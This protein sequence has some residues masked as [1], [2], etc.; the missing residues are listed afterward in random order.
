MF[1]LESKMEEKK[2]NHEIKG[3]WQR[4]FRLHDVIYMFNVNGRLY[5]KKRE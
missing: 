2:S 1:V 3:L 4:S 5:P